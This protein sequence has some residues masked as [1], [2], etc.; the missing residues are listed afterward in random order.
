MNTVDTKLLQLQHKPIQNRHLNTHEQKNAFRS[1]IELAEG[2]LNTY[3]FKKITDIV[4]V[5]DTFKF[6][7]L[8]VKFVFLINQYTQHISRL[9]LHS[10]LSLNVFKLVG[11]F[12]ETVHG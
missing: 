10:Y 4:L 9:S 7:I 12:H 5:T 2:R 8:N 1:N 6:R 11:I 3:C